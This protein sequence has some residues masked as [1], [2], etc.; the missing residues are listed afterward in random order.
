MNIGDFCLNVVHAIRDRRGVELEAPTGIRVAH[1][2]RVVCS[3]IEP[4]K[5]VG[6]GTLR[7]SI[8][9]DL[10]CGH[11]LEVER[12]AGDLDRVAVLETRQRVFDQTDGTLVRHVLDAS[13][14]HLHLVEL[15]TLR[16]D[17][18]RTNGEPVVTGTVEAA[19]MRAPA[20]IEA[21]PE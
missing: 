9:E 19:R 7:H 13:E 15:G 16:R 8:D 10:D 20:S 1:E 11:A 6:R 14:R 3:D 18:S 2:A 5:A 12:P 21:K 17:V 4:R